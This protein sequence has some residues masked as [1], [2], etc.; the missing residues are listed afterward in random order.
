M[1]ANLRTTTKKPRVRPP[2]LDENSAIEKLQTV[3]LLVN[4]RGCLQGWEVERASSAVA[5]IKKEANVNDIYQQFLQN[6][7]RHSKP[8]N[9]AP[10]A[11]LCAIA[12]GK[13][14]IKNARKHVFLN[15]PEKIA[16]LEDSL[17]NDAL[18]DDVEKNADA[19]QLY[20]R[21]TASH[22]QGLERQI[23]SPE[24]AYAFNKQKMQN[25]NTRIVLGSGLEVSSTLPPTIFAD[26]R[27]SVPLDLQLRDLIDFL[28]ELEGPNHT[29][30]M[31]CPL[32]GHP[33]PSIYLGTQQFGHASAKLEFSQPLA[34]TFMRYMM[35]RRQ[36]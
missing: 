7:Q 34:T 35:K 25:T 20:N 17:V 26:D 21:H 2:K 30:R 4:K 1:S 15:L 19:D 9:A 24:G 8:K 14:A 11:R 5:L 31:R 10:L 16:A 29:L 33:L 23:S 27:D 18:K 22:G 6:V 13:D 12:L 36:L 32:S 3:S 28:Y